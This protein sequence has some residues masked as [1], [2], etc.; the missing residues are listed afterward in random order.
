M[1][2]LPAIV[3]ETAN[4]DPE[5]ET[6]FEFEMRVRAALEKILSQDLLRHGF[7]APEVL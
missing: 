1:P 4:Q 7:I 2:V 6:D 5:A 3:P